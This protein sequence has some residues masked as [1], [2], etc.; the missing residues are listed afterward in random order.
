MK[1][2]DLINDYKNKIKELKKHNDLYFNKDKPI[3]TDAEYD[4]LKKTLQIL[5]NKNTFLKEL[6][7]LSSIVG[8]KPLN[9][10]I[11]F[12]EI[13]TCFFLDSLAF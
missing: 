6:N 2:R 10:I 3:I 1:K 11:S 5:Q 12:T 8:A 7:L 13:F 4:N 9:F